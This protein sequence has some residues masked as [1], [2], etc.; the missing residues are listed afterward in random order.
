MH[1]Q[2]VSGGYCRQCPACIDEYV[3]YGPPVLRIHAASPTYTAGSIGPDPG[4][5]LPGKPA[6]ASA[7]PEWFQL[8][9]PGQFT[10]RA[11]ATASRVGA[12]P[13]KIELGVG[14]RLEA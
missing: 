1:H 9:V 3:R 2:D 12:C 8:G 7:T 11:V 14:T 5:H 6:A 10:S 13:L 4:S